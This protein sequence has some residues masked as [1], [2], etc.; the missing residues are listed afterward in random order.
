MPV[1]LTVACRE[2]VGFPECILITA[3]PFA[4]CLVR[5]FKADITAV[6]KRQ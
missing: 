2:R 6:I 5:V 1:S 3:T 4:R